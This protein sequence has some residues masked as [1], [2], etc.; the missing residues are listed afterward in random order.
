MKKTESLYPGHRFPK[1]WYGVQPLAAYESKYV[2]M[3]IVQSPMAA[4]GH[5]RNWA[6]SEVRRG[7]AV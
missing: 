2:A 4:K 6:V 3:F 1:R 5:R 7:N